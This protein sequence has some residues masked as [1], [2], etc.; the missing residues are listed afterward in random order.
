[1]NR[2]LTKAYLRQ[3][4]Q[5]KGPGLSTQSTPYQS[6][7]AR[8]SIPRGSSSSQHQHMFIDDKEKE[9]VRQ[10]SITFNK[11]AEIFGRMRRNQGK[12]QKQRGVRAARGAVLKT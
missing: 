4:R 10:D 2:D 8:P 5:K 12:S 3:Q 7:G 11:V 9:K 1:M 6:T